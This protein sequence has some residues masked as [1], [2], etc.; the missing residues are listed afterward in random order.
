MSIT[1]Q[2]TY[3]DNTKLAAYKACPRSYFLRH[4]LH[5]TLDWG[6]LKAPAL[7]FGSAWHEGMDAIWGN[8]GIPQDEKVTLAM[9][10]FYVSWVSDGYNPNPDFA[11]VETLKAR[12]PGNAHEMFH[13]YVAKYER[14]L[15]ECNVLAIE[16]PI[17]VPFPAL[18]DTWYIG[19]LDKVF[20][21]NGVHIGEHK[22]TS[23]YAIKGQFQPDW[24]ESW[25]SSSQ[26][27]G[28]QLAGTMYYP[29][30][31]DVWVDGALVHNKVH[32]AF[33]RIP[34][35]HAMP[36]LEEWL[37]DTRR[38]I[39]KIQD[40]IRTFSVEGDLE[41]GAFPR[42]E[43]NCFGKYSKCPFLNICSTCSDPSQLDGPPPGYKVE[44]WEPFDELGID[45]LVG[46]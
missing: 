45:R 33:I 7:V 2:S 19:K 41:S 23:A 22:T 32:D 16:Q 40:D 21:W 18:D 43:D 27:K 11:E 46:T 5:W 24:T 29:S 28:Y 44:K 3:F 38:W 20:E 9:D 34:V 14:M 1:R 12:T 42:N 31:R 6:E 15:E 13:N 8:Q 35:S 10:A 36:L 30:L 26:V 39:V 25:G 4:V 37:R 17:A